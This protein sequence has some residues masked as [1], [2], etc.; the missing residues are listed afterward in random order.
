MNEHE[1]LKAICEK[2]WYNISNG[3]FE[4]EGMLYFKSWYS[5]V[6][7]DVREI[8][9]TQEFMDKLSEYLNKNSI[10]DFKKM[11]WDICN[12]LDNPV[13]FLYNLIK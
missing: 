13:E 5:Y 10:K 7:I 12:N 3:Y 2:I 4:I 9:F 8:I 1:K 6:D 11:W